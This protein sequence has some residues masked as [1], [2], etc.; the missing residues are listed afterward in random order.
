VSNPKR[1]SCRASPSEIRIEVRPLESWLLI[2]HERC[3]SAK[4]RIDN[5]FKSFYF[6]KFIDCWF[7]DVFYFLCRFISCLLYLSCVRKKTSTA[8]RKLSRTVF[9]SSS[10]CC[11]A[12]LSNLKSE[13]HVERISPEPGRRVSV[14]CHWQRLATDAEDKSTKLH[15][16]EARVECAQRCQYLTC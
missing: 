14:L 1:P 3:L 7:C 9:F 6:F 16:R 2:Q 5:Y 15:Q 11:I 10:Y 4:K 8:K 12:R 13:D